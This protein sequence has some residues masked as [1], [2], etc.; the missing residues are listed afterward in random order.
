MCG[1]CKSESIMTHHR[2]LVRSHGI[3]KRIVAAQ[4]IVLATIVST[5]AAST[6]D[7]PVVAVYR[8]LPDV[9]AWKTVSPP[10]IF[11]WSTPKLFA[12]KDTITVSGT[13]TRS[14]TISAISEYVWKDSRTTGRGTFR[15]HAKGLVYIEQDEEGHLRHETVFRVANWNVMPTNGIWRARTCDGRQW[16]GDLDYPVADNGNR[17]PADFEERIVQD[18]LRKLPY[19][20]SRSNLLS[21]CAQLDGIYPVQSVSSAANGIFVAGYIVNGQRAG[22]WLAARTSGYLQIEYFVAGNPCG[23]QIVS[24]F[25]FPGYFQSFPSH[26]QYAVSLYYVKGHINSLDCRGSS[27]TNL[28]APLV[29]ATWQNAKLNTIW[30]ESDGRG[31]NGVDILWPIM[32]VRNGGQ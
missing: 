22:L 7:D 18:V 15:E 1:A 25:G 10:L 23:I 21:F 26:S 29:K 24:G 32:P 4:G 27:A 16:S 8:M 12:E 31:T 11:P 6:N 14:T 20:D 30:L 2:R 17:L 5:M 28:W 9:L 13:F 19:R 3:I